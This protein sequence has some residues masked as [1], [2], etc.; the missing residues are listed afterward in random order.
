M[1]SDRV[2]VWGTR[3]GKA[4]EQVQQLCGRSRWSFP[5]RDDLARIGKIVT[6]IHHRDEVSQCV[7]YGEQARLAELAFEE[8]VDVMLLHSG[9]LAWG[10]VG[11]AKDLTLLWD[12]VPWRKEHGD[13][14][15]C[16]RATP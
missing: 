8:R 14:Q 10:D 3:S 13:E 12:E 15:A 6:H 4:R 9:S 2:N 5:A 11:S 16:S 7:G 1:R